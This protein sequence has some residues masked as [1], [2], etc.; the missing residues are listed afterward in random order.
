MQGLKYLSAL[1]PLLKSLHEVGCQRDTAGNRKLHMDEYCMLV[2]LWLY[3]PLLTSLRAL[4]QASTLEKVRRKFKIPRASLGS[5][6]E[7]VQVFDPE[8]LKHIAEQ[9][10]DQI[11]DS[12]PAGSNAGKLADV[13]RAR[14]IT[15]VDG[16][17][18]KLLT[19]IADLAW[20]KIGDK[21]ATCG[22]R[23][24]TQFE[25]MRGVPNRIDATSANPKGKNDE[26]AVLARTLESD[27]FYV[28]DRG[29]G[30]WPLFNAI[31][32]KGSSYICR[33][34]DGL[35]YQ[36][37]E[38]RPLSAADRAAGVVSDELIERTAKTQSDLVDHPIRLV[39]V[40]CSPHTSRG[41]YCKGRYHS[42]GPSSDGVLRLLTNDVDLPAE[43]I[44]EMYAQRW[45]IEIFFRMFKQLLGCRHLLSTK[46]QGVEIQVY[47]AIIAC[48]LI[49]IYTGSR[50]TKRTFEMACFYL[51]GWATL[52][53]L[54]SHIKKLK[55][56]AA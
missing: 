51:S 15:A 21:P 26:R 23:L 13:N 9:L 20:I 31:V 8:L 56:S 28:M 16:S 22:Y 35:K 36:A 43:L 49:M 33:M 46:Q 30:K 17:V 4:Q 2:L 29:Y 34:R 1:R 45:T 50:P 10:G 12:V 25:I 44:A 40:K 27:R 39:C 53:E 38:T 54:T 47:C 41:R 48:M 6:S 7:S 11:P 3:S 14:T 52:E 24:H 37:T 32:A 19:Q 42:T 55:P 18:V 5:L